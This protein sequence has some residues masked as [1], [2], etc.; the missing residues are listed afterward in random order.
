MTSITLHIF[1]NLNPVNALESVVVR[2]YNQAGDTFVTQL[3]SGSDG[4]VTT[5]IPDA[6]YWVWFYKQGYS[7]TS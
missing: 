1:D 4:K 5:D 2:I 3:T 7:F 6:T